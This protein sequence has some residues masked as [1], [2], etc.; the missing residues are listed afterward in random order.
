MR[1]EINTVSIGSFGRTELC[2]SS[3]EPGF[4]THHCTYICTCHGG[5]L[6][7]WICWL[8]RGWWSDW[9]LIHYCWNMLN[10]HSRMLVTYPNT[11]F[12][13]DVW[14]FPQWGIYNTVATRGKGEASSGPPSKREIVIYIERAVPA[15]HILYTGKI[16]SKNPFYKMA[17]HATHKI[18][19]VHE[20]SP[21]LATQPFGWD[22]DER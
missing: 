9:G 15:Y 8:S 5:A 21:T 14:S 11:K 20:L 3:T 1:I 2:S 4:D 6:Q 7:G 12:S 19:N 13:L 10:L 18:D 22:G 17:G 16:S